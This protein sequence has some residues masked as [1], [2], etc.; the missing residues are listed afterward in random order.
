MQPSQP[1]TLGLFSFETE[2]KEISERVGDLLKLLPA[3]G[4]AV[5]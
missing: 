1:Y 5:T 3:P 2:E 4:G